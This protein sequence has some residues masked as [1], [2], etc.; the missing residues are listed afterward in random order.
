MQARAQGP[1]ASSQQSHLAKLR[2][3]EPGVHG[4][5]DA[6]LSLVALRHDKTAGEGVYVVITSDAGEMRQALSP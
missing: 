2:H 5:R 6:P 3:T 1:V 4:T